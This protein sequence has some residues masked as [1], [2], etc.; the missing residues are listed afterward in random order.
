[1]RG[2][3]SLRRRPAGS[4]S[5][6]VARGWAGMAAR[7]ALP[8]LKAGRSRT[9]VVLL[10]GVVTL[11]TRGLGADGSSDRCHERRRDEHLGHECD[12]HDHG[13]P[14]ENRGHDQSYG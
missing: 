8:S 7:R 2:S 3:R 10:G 5:L 1:M 13:A 11:V 4:G 6:T 12:A 9:G 14:A